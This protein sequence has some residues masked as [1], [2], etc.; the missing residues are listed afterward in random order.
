MRNYFLFILISL[1]N[2]IYSCGFYPYGEDTRIS[3]FNPKT[4]GFESFSHFNYS[5]NSFS[6]FG[7]E[8]IQFADNYIDPNI[9]LWFDYCN[10]NVKA[11]QINEAIYQ[12]EESEMNELSPNAFIQY[13]YKN[14]NKEAL[15][16]L[17]F[18]KNCE[19]YNSWFEDPWE[20]KSYLSIPKRT[21]LMNKAI[22]LSEKVENK[23]LKKRY[24]FLAIRLA[25]YN[26]LD[27]KVKSLFLKEFENTTKKDILYYWSLYFKSLSEKDSSYSN[28]LLAQVFANAI[29]KR[30]VCHQHFNK[31]IPLENTLKFAKN[32]E[33]KA[34]VYLMYGIEKYD[35]TLNYIKKIHEYNPA[36]EGLSF[37]LLREINKIEDFVLTPYYTL[38]Q[39]SVSN[40]NWDEE[41]EP[42]VQKILNRTE[43]DRIYAKQVLNFIS[44]VDL[45][46]VNNPIFWETCKSYLQFI[47]RDYNSCLILINEIEKTVKDSALE[48]QIKQLKTLALIANQ[49]Y[50]SAV[51]PLNT[52]ETI[53]L[54]KNN[55]K[56]IFSIA[57][58]LEYLGNTT[59]A[60]LLYS[61]LS[62]I[63]YDD[64]YQTV[65]WK[66]GKNKIKTD[67]LS[68]YFTDYFDYID[69]V[70]SPEQVQNIIESVQKE[71]EEKTKFSSF[72]FD[73]IKNEIPKFYDLLGTKYIRQN[74]LNKALNTFEKIDQPYWKQAYPNWNDNTNIFD[75]NPFYNL[76]YT[77]H[78]I[79]K[80]DKIRLN[81]Y[82]ITK[83][84]IHYLNKAE[85][86]NEKNRDYYYFLVANA[87]YNMGNEGNIWMMR[88]FN[89]W[90]E[91]SLS[92]IE[93]EVEFRQSNLAKKYYS[94]AM[95]NASTKKF[96]AL[97]LRM[98]TRC[99]RRKIE[100][101]YIEN[102]N[103]NT[104]DFDS[105]LYTN[106]YYIDLKKQYPGYFNE[107]VSNC[108]YFE[109]YFDSRR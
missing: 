60:A 88:R 49:S 9:Q 92:E 79:D 39:P 86:K 52:Y 56:F 30:F 14:K 77:P 104:M 19:H 57:K 102:P 32:N 53:I 82:T 71:N 108:N 8:P 105:L 27:D 2:S 78:F 98:L 16:Y 54:N 81:K 109:S 63:E 87:Y 18:A 33:E 101:Q 11:T 37:L 20:R 10:G 70:Y 15:N 107:L 61:K 50:G 73:V 67:Y 75:Q 59:D 6:Q 66:S 93:D 106:K 3:I 74:K 85:D 103:S 5:S 89:E 29:D 43:Q 1:S 65:Y 40:Q 76:K 80:K 28:Y 13:L 25:W 94:L 100:F 72:K 96:K 17:R 97:C 35:K 42:S 99:E 48:N 90:S 55:G 47:T 36:S 45:R 69:V 22:N 84:L 91:Y 21:E 24:T 23:E 31:K 12:L 46:K 4:F 64:G 26:Q 7:P 58:E 95:Q 51:I 41:N 68:N 62:E 83:Q 34:N 44:T 38:F